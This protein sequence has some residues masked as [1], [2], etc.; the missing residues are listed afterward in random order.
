M[1]SVSSQIAHDSQKTPRH[2]YIIKS[3]GVIGF[4]T[5]ISRLLGYIR[6]MILAN[7]FG[8]EMV[9]DV[10]FVAF[11]IPSLIKRL[12]GEGSLSSSFIPVFTDYLEKRKKKEAWELAS[13]VLCLV[14]VAAI[15]LTLLAILAAPG[16]VLII[17]PGFYPDKMK[18]RLT[19]LITRIIFPYIIIASIVAVI[20]GILNS[21][22]HFAIP[23]LSPAVLNVGII[24][25]ALFLAPKMNQPITGVAFGVLIGGLLQILIHPPVLIKKGALLKPSF[26]LHNPGTKKIG[27]LM[28]PAAIGLGVTQI[29]IMIDTLLAS[30]LP[31]G[32]ISYLYYSNRLLQLPLALFGIALGTALLPTYSSLISSGRADEVMSTFS[33]AMRVVLFISLPSSIGLIVFRVPIIGILFQ[34]GQFTNAATTATAQ[35][36]FAYSIGLFAYSGLKVTIPV[37][38]AHQDT[39][40]PV[41][42]GVIAMLLNICINLILMFPLKH[43]GLALATSL[44]SMMNLILLIRIM[45]NRWG[46]IDGDRITKSCLK[47]LVN[48]LFMG[49]IC[50]WFI[51]NKI[52]IFLLPGRLWIK[53]LYLGLGIGFGFIVYFTLSYITGSTEMDFFV[54]HFITRKADKGLLS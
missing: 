28:V 9:A 30:F 37:F 15:L 16:I 24:F 41:R 25:G 32:S 14:S 50:Y 2:K 42:I 35:A 4:A 40:T 39:I 22:K 47:S 54:S 6:D 53:A 51:H 45:R 31:E 38:Y 11:K 21:L 29:N 44:S 43:A 3:A 5:I 46:R 8:T 18:F 27:L 48:S 19:V 10:F 13:N 34:R 49:L 23:A 17:A 7:I 33:F 20:M 12:L 52:W 26:D 36:L 1:S